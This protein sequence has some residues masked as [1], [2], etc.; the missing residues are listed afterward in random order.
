MAHGCSQ[1]SG[2]IQ[3]YSSQLAMPNTKVTSN[4]ITNLYKIDTLFRVM[5]RMSGY[6]AQKSYKKSGLK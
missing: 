4:M 2:G 5:C 1:A 6:R 3:S